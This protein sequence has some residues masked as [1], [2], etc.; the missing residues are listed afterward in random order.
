[1]AFK[2]TNRLKVNNNNF[3]FNG[4]FKSHIT[5]ERTPSISLLKLDGRRI[6]YIMAFKLSMARKMLNNHFS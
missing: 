2:I 1:M 3:K 6:G 4:N 5:A